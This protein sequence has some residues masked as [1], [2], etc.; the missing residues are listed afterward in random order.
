MFCCFSE[1]FEVDISQ[2]Y[3]FYGQGFSK[4][5]RK[6]KICPC[7]FELLCAIPPI[8]MNGRNCGVFAEAK[9]ASKNFSVEYSKSVQ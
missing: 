7:V 2:S 1:S 6:V 5:Y 9:D 3:G 8:K 4:H